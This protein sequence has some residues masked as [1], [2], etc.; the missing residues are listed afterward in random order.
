MQG[1]SEVGL[2]VA[3]IYPNDVRHRSRQHFPPSLDP[4][5]KTHIV[6]LTTRESTPKPHIKPTVER[7][8]PGADQ[9]DGEI[10]DS[11]HAGLTSPGSPA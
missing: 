10:Q 1:L 4:F 7:R 11:L 6:L 5:C 2:V 9:V 8:E 3:E